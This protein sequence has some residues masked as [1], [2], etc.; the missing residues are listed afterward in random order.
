MV[1]EEFLKPSRE[2]LA[3]IDG[4]IKTAEHRMVEDI[5]RYG[6]GDREYAKQRTREFYLSVEPLRRERDGVVKVIADYYGTQAMPPTL[7][8][9]G[10]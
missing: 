6:H 4:M 8:S 2:H 10:N 3:Y 1:D 7:V 5:K 9:N